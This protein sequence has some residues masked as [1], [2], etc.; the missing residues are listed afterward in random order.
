MSSRAPVA[1][2]YAAFVLVGVNAG[3]KGVLL[4]A[5]MDDY[6]VSRTTL[7]LTFFAGSAGFVLAGLTVGALIDRFGTRI[8]LVAGGCAYVLASLYAA[9]RP[10]FMAFVALQV[11]FGCAVGV[12]ESVL[13]VHL[14]GLPGATTRLNRLHGFFG[15][16]ALLGPPLA[17]WTVSVASWPTVMLLLAVA[18]VPL[19]AGFLIA[20]PRTGPVPAPAG[21]PEGLA[22][23][24]VRQ[25]GVLLG[26]AL[27]AVYVGLELGVGN[28][29]FGY[30][31]DERGQTEVLAGYAVSGY[32]LGLTAGRFLLSPIVT[33]L[34]LTA[35]G[36]MHTCL[37]GVT[38]VAAL[39]WLLPH[40]AAATAGLVLLGFF[41]GPVFPTAMAVAPRLTTARLVPAAIGIMNAGSVVGGAAFPWL[42]GAIAEGVGVWTLLPFTLA[43]ALIQYAIWW[44]MARGAG[45][46]RTGP[47]LS[48][49]P[50]PR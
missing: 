37:L 4:A 39:T 24:A 14:S 1:L 19:T 17:A 45:A 18:T 43:L 41:L 50:P 10:A 32:W 30:L 36:L 48:P 47:G 21:R 23:S 44:P 13:N 25:P 22:R 31:V 28:W 20:F 49:S 40:E 16:G 7:G 46:R 34:G 26:A 35:I 27:L 3:V 42:A 33:R 11:A 8:V 6:A 2:A 12:L 9:T 38:V 5:Q 15:V 29:A